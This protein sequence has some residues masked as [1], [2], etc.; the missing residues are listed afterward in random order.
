MKFQATA[1]PTQKELSTEYVQSAIQDFKHDLVFTINRSIVRMA[2]Y[3]EN[4]KTQAEASRNLA[5]EEMTAIFVAVGQKFDEY[6]EKATEE[7]V[8]IDDCIDNKEHEILDN[9]R[10][11]LF[12][13]TTCHEES[14]ADV[15]KIMDDTN[16]DMFQVSRKLESLQE[17]L[18][19][20]ADYSCLVDVEDKLIIAKIQLPMEVENFEHQFQSIADANAEKVL[21]C[22]IKGTG[23]FKETTAVTMEGVQECIK[24]KFE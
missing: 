9:E 12:D 18:K 20:C 11:T 24:H 4:H 21:G 17:E 7:G 10:S 22:S 5:E 2:Q 13:I 23:S 6:R 15:Q 3:L 8:E 14:F 19:T 16:F 1:K